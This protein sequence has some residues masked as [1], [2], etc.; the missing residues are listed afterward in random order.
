MEIF[1]LFIFFVFTF[2]CSFVLFKYYD[3]FAKKFNCFD[4][5]NNLNV[6]VKPTPTSAGIVFIFILLPSILFLQF[7]Y[8]LE[9]PKNYLLFYFGIFVLF[10]IGFIDDQKDIHP[11]IRLGVQISVI[12]ICLAILYLQSVNLPLKFSMLI[13]L[14]FWVY[15]LNII[16]FTDGSDGFLATNSIVFFF[17]I[18]LFCLLNKNYNLSFSISLSFLPILF[19]YLVF[20]KP[21]AK[22]FMGDS[23]SL[24]IGFCV[25]YCSIELILLGEI[26]LVISYLSYTL[27]DCTYT[28]IKKVCNGYYPWA[29]MFD[30]QFLKPLKNNKDHNYIFINNLTFNFINLIIIGIQ[31]FYDLEILCLLS[32]FLSIFF[33]IKYNK[34]F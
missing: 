22:I 33:I 12:Y 24:I 15:L 14:Y 34:N 4:I 23:G 3:I 21:K 2:S 18:L 16:N 9:L 27:I 10:L 25:G 29:R 17:S 31:I 30:Y 7:Y 32:I 6:H 20:N 26:Y 11:F 5:P 1:N 28:I 13:V 19:A 8:S